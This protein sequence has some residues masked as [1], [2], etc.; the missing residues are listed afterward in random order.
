MAPF[1][2][3]A[4]T[5]VRISK[6]EIIGRTLMKRKKSIVNKPIVPKN[7]IRSQRVGQYIP[8][9]EGRKSR[10]RLV[11]TISNR[12]SHMPTL[13]NIEMK[14]SIAGDVR[15]LLIH[16]NCGITMLQRIRDQ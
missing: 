8:H 11:T 4:G 7:V 2:F 14:K 15:M 16:R 1:T 12:S 10:C 9:D 13:T 3:A 5:I 6:I